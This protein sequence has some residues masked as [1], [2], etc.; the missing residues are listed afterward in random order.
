M[1]LLTYRT[2]AG[3]ALGIK[4]PPGI[5]DVAAAAA[6][7]GPAGL[8]ATPD[9]VIAAGSAAIPRL[10]DLAARA[11]GRPELLCTEAE[12][13]Y[14]PCVPSPGKIICVGHNYRR[15]VVESGAT[16]PETPVLFSK[17]NNTIAAPG[18]AI[19][20]PANAVEYDYEVELC[21]VIGKRTRYVSE[22]DALSHVLG[23]CNANDLSTRDL[24]MRTSQWLLGKTQD[25][26]MPIGP[27]LVTADEV[28]DPQALGLRCWVNGEQRQDSHTADMIF[29]VAYLISYI[30]QYFTLEPG[31]LISTGTPEG[32]VIGMKEKV[33]L[34]P[35][36]T[37]T[38]EIDKLGRLTNT[39]VAES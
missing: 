38:V 23:Y 15:H 37:T 22:A 27:Y 34:R 7:L 5:V 20:L 32:V 35:G 33:W 30:S 13:A 39:F 11:A 8:P 9:A 1:I 28:G 29:P 16:M 10:A 19:P 24:Q 6:A 12:L 17:F 18:E 4:T 36:D 25:K 2:P 14:G 3:L 26:F 21:A 31:D